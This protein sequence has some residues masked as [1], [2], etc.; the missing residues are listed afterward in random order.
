MAVNY[1]RNNFFSILGKKKAISP[2]FLELLIAHNVPG[3]SKYVLSIFYLLG[4]EARCLTCSHTSKVSLGW[5][6]LIHCMAL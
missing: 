5:D 1:F 2:P 3:E 6:I 4:H